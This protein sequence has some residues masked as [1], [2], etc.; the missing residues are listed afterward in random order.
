MAGIKSRDGPKMAAPSTRP[1]A[2]QEIGKKSGSLLDGNA[3]VLQVGLEFARLEH[4]AHDIGPADEL[5]HRAAEWSANW[6]KP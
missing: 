2:T 5:A 1:G 4:L 3:G 6:C